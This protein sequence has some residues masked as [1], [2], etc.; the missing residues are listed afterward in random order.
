MKHL[1]ETGCSSSLPN[2]ALGKTFIQGWFRNLLLGSNHCESKSALP[3]RLL[4][5]DFLLSVSVLSLILVIFRLV[6]P[7]II[8]CMRCI[9]AHIDLRVF[10]AIIAVSS[11]LQGIVD[12]CLLVIIGPRIVIAPQSVHADFTRFRYT[13]HRSLVRLHVILVVDEDL[14]HGLGQKGLHY[15]LWGASF[16]LQGL[17][18]TIFL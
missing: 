1:S 3:H 10:R 2:S 9:F 7:D 16:W 18:D 13:H 4:R 14:G 5:C 17:I 8:K 11:I 12:N 6:K 15:L